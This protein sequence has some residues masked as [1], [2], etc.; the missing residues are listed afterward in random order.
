MTTLAPRGKHPPQSL[1]EEADA[2]E[3]PR[4]WC[5]G[6]ERDCLAEPTR[7]R[8]DRGHRG[9]PQGPT[10]RRPQRHHDDQPPMRETHM[11]RGP[12]SSVAMTVRFGGGGADT[13]AGATRRIQSGSWVSFDQAVGSGRSSHIS[14]RRRQATAILSRQPL[15]SS[16]NASLRIRRQLP[17]RTP[18]PHH[19]QDRVHHRPPRML[20]P[21]ATPRIPGRRRQQRLDQRPL[22]IAQIRGVPPHARHP[23]RPAQPPT[24][25]SRRHAANLI[26]ISNTL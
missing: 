20:L 1:I 18:G 12:P 6:I 19:I 9:G 3:T 22:L 24:P 5:V 10:P 4:A 13:P 21:P 26:K 17:P 8:R 2:R 25:R 7:L 16:T 14:G 15:T 23:I 11:P